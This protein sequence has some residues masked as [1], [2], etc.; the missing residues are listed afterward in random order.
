LS[1]GNGLSLFLTE[2]EA[3][4]VLKRASHR[5]PN[6]TRQAINSTPTSNPTDSFME[7]A[8]LRLGEGGHPGE[9]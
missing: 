9:S 1:R 3:V 8:R 5:R 4:V 7:P 2:D 6:A